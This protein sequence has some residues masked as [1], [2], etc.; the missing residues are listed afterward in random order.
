M[1]IVYIGQKIIKNVISKEIFIFLERVRSTN[2]IENIQNM[3][4]KKNLLKIL[5]FSILLF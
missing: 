5:Y 3:L 1:Y 4:N 2:L